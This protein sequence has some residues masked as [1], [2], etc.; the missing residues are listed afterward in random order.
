[1][2]ILIALITGLI[3]GFAS[4]RYIT[5]WLESS[6]LHII[7]IP[8]LV[9]VGNA[10]NVTFITF[11][12]GGPESNTS[13]T[14]DGAVS[15]LTD[16]NGMLTLM[17]NATTGGSIN[18]SAAKEDYRNATSYITAIPGLV[19]SSVPASLPS[20]TATF[21]TFSV[22]SLG[23]PV[24]DV[25]VNLSGAGISLDGITNTN[26][27][28]VMQ[29]NPPKTGTI[30][31]AARKKDYT[32]GS[33]KITSTS[34]ETLNISSS[35]STVTVNVPIYITFTVTASGSTVRDALV[36]LEGAAT[37]SGITNQNGQVI[38][39]VNPISAGGI[40]ATATKNGFSMGTMNLG[41]S[42]QQSLGVSANPSNLSNGE[43]S[44]VTFTVKSR[45]YAVSGATVSVSGGGISTDGVT[46]SA[47]QVTLE[48]NAQDYGTI[49]VTARKTGF[50]DGLTT[51]EH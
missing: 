13:V 20:N 30:Y 33:T 12:N 1:M 48:L 3:A 7:G 51:I 39:L 34:Q 19:I 32:E 10:T 49:R 27:E 18:I 50:F 4:D 8:T 9:G 47:G 42:G 40:T 38:L 28:I 11:S 35:Q 29:V 22:T 15:G 25:L 36:N 17:V 14:L 37:G 43:N 23:K 24:G 6:Q 31:A 21:V 5:G 44:Y 2:F 16:T 41:A 26:G 45:G 46:N